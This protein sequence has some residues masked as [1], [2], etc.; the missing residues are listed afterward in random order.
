MRESE[1]DRLNNSIM[2]EIMPY[3]DNLIKERDIARIEIIRLRK[4]I[5]K[6]GLEQ[7]KCKIGRPRKV[8]IKEIADSKATVPLY[9]SESKKEIG[10]DVVISPLLTTKE[11]SHLLKLADITVKRL[12]YSGEIASMKIGGS[13]R[14][15]QE[16]VEKFIKNFSDKEAHE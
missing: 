9:K 8:E 13:R 2:S 15:R 4:I 11:V 14:I 3:F 10:T 16:D 1:R 5:Y 7:Q 6:A 12:V